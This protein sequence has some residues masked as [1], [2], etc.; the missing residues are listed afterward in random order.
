MKPETIT[1]LLRPNILHLTPYSSARSE[2]DGAEGIFLDANENPYNTDYNRYPD[3]LQRKLKEKLAQTK[4]VQPSNIFLGNGSDEAI[5]IALR[6]FCNPHADNIVTITPTYGMYKV[7]AQIND[8]ELREVPLN[9]DF[10]LNTQAVLQA[11]DAHTKMIILCSPNNPTGNDLE[12]SS[13]LHLLN[14]FSGIIAIDEAYI[15]FAQG[16]SR[17]QYLPQYPRLIVWQTFSKAWAMAGLRLGIAFAHEELIAVFNKV[18]Y[19]YNINAYTQQKALEMLQQQP[20]M[21]QQVN[22]I[23]QERQRLQKEFAQLKYVKTVYPTSANFILIQ[24]E[25]A[26]RLY[27]YL[28]AQHIIVRNRTKVQL[29]GNCVRITVGTAHE[30]DALLQ[31]MHLFA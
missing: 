21:L 15:D 4:G 25:D 9:A 19:P 22:T 27:D 23:L 2:F 6:S 1:S 18:K 7:L 29:C 13:M 12:W 14:N 17:L 24:V 30:N 31:A 10:S 11:V 3:P 20:T 8:V 16:A 26:N 5:D 28:L